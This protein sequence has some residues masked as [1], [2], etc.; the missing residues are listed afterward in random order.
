QGN[1]NAL[2]ESTDTSVDALAAS[3]GTLS[4][5]LTTFTGQ[6]TALQTLA[7][8]TPVSEQITTA[9][10]ALTVTLAA[11][12][13][14]L[15]ARIDTLASDL[16]TEVATL[17]GNI[18]ALSESTDTSV[19]ALTASLGTL[20]GELTTLTGQ[21]TALQTL[22][23]DTPVSEQITTAIDALTVTLEA[24][25]VA[26]G[27][28]ID[29]L[30]SD[31]STEVATLQ[32]NINA[33]SESTD[34]SV[35]ALTASLGTLSGELT[36]LTG[37]VTALQ[38][39]VG[40]TPVSEQITTAIDALTVTLAA[41]DAALGA[42]ID[43]LASDLSTEVTTLQGN[44]NALSESTDTSVDALT[45]SLTTLS[46]N[47]T[48]LTGQVTA[49]QTLVGDTPVS[50]QITT[51]IAGM[52]EAL[53]APATGEGE[54]VTPATGVFA[55]IAAAEARLDALEA[56]PIAWTDEGLEYS[57]AEI[58]GSSASSAVLT[59]FIADFN[60]AI[61]GYDA[62]TIPMTIT[63][64]LTVAQATALSQA[65]FVL[66]G[67]NVTYAIN[68]YY[69]TVQAALADP[70]QN[71]ALTGATEVVAKGD[72]LDNTLAMTAFDQ[73]VNLRIVADDG[74]DIIN[75]GRGDDV[76]V[77]GEGA[78]TINLTFRDT[79]SDTVVYQDVTDG[80]GLPVT[81][82]NFSTDENDYRVGSV[83]SVTV[84]GHLYSHTMGES[85]TADTAL[86]VLAQL[87]E[88]D[89]S[90]IGAAQVQPG[91]VINLVGAEA[92]SDIV[93]AATGEGVPFITNNGQLHI[94]TVTFDTETTNYIQDDTFPR[95]ISVT[96]AGVKISADM[97][98]GDPMASVNALVTAINTARDSVSDD[99]TALTA[100]IA[101]VNDVTEGTAITL[102]A[103]EVYSTD[104]AVP[105][106]VTAPTL[107][108]AGEQQVAEVS[109][110][111]DPDDYFEG[112]K[113]RVTIANEDFEADMV[114][115]DANASVANLEAKIEAARVGVVVVEATPTTINDSISAVEVTGAENIEFFS[116][117]LRIG[118]TFFNTPVPVGSTLND[119]VS[120]LSTQ[121]SA[122]GAA[123]IVEGDVV[124][125][126]NADS[127]GID[128]FGT[129]T[130]YGNYGDG[131][132]PI[133]SISSDDVVPGSAE[134]IDK[135]QDS[136][137]IEGFA[138]VLDGVE[139][140]SDDVLTTAEFALSDGNTDISYTFGADIAASGIITVATGLTFLASPSLG[141]YNPFTL[142]S[143]DF[144]D[145]AAFVAA[146]QLDLTEKTP[147]GIL[148][149]Y[150]PQAG[151]I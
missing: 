4:G 100:A 32:G 59:T 146:I 117:N 107:D 65:G 51:A 83:L 116:N 9:I 93:V 134:I 111:T 121:F 43:T 53:G 45:T 18:N 88:T 8:E 12:D 52:K 82:L 54:N 98:E 5:E 151:A 133:V 128:V 109:F 26:L 1:I 39:L 20:S 141:T 79:S 34:T 30:A 101:E 15:G 94:K 125:T 105:F 90:G 36:T 85:E 49:L 56:Q 91:G 31:L 7:G 11:A 123:S 68:D 135:S 37:Q 142:P 78:D 38:T 76:I 139:L 127:Y 25:D 110:S 80:G 81:A 104:D 10:D 132:I 95:Q 33:L 92:G 77:G 23:G 63:T 35:D 41:A 113:L 138:D 87:I 103:A 120:A 114:A 115:G 108:V 40:D 97:V 124:F 89:E 42:R 64:D 17:Q 13:A 118:D 136:G 24:A 21:V 73:S 72:E 131:P 74:D 147:N 48:T 57:A 129:L 143:G 16:S 84:N 137:F 70:D 58:F 2:S 67:M 140:G 6:V 102:V 69:T 55:M 46:S 62:A 28:R 112:G 149:T 144:A 3:L 61:N 122:Y 150:D 75:A 99:G 148:F 106:A 29:D 44:I 50:E 96:I 19:D 22:V 86:G 60:T 145:M 14:A 119:V 126:M 66:D 27:E 130:V 71:A 47:L